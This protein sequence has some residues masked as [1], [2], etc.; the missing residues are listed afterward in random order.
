MNTCYAI[1]DLISLLMRR[2]FLLRKKKLILTF[3]VIY[4]FPREKILVKN[5]PM[6]KALKSLNFSMKILNENF[7]DFKICKLL[8]LY[9]GHI[10]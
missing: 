9:S 6:K 10:Y 3:G 4:D 1:M 2:N 7:K 5:F 8:Y